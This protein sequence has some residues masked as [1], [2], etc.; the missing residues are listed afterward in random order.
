MPHGKVPTSCRFSWRSIRALEE[1]RSWVCDGRDLDLKAGRAHV[2]QTAYAVGRDVKFGEPKTSRSRRTIGLTPRVVSSL[3]RHRVEQ[4][5]RRLIRGEEWKELDLVV[6][7]GD[8]D[9]LHPDVLSRYFQRLVDR[10]GFAG[11]QV[12]DL[13]HAFATNLMRL[14]GT[15][16]TSAALGHSSEAFT[17][18][19]YQHL[20]PDANADLVVRAISRVYG[21]E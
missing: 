14:V 11:V 15:K 1:A 5:R 9:A 19:V 4:A 8:G 18:R 16:D 12:H 7:R 10:S 20:V 13:R 2:N 3:R 21:D 6:D 17:M